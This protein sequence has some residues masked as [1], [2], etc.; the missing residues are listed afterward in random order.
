MGEGSD[1]GVE[2]WSRVRGVLGWRD[3]GRRYPGSPLASFDEDE[4]RRRKKK[5]EKERRLYPRRTASPHKFDTPRISFLTGCNA[6]VLTRR[7]V[8]YLLY[9]NSSRSLSALPSVFRR[10]QPTPCSSARI[11]IC[12][13]VGLLAHRVSSRRSVTATL[14]QRS[15]INYPAFVTRSPQNHRLAFLTRAYA[16]TH[17][18][19]GPLRT[20]IQD[21]ANHAAWF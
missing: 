4:T 1:G 2:V 12:P 21:S 19:L 5:K 20:L 11:P 16:Y 18:R 15:K 6:N 13:S 17:I 9:D 14:N 10:S 7:I 3:K 8:S